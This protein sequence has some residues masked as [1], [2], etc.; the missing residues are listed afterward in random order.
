MQVTI[1]VCRITNRI[2]KS[3]FR[4]N[5][6][7]RKVCEIFKVSGRYTRMPLTSS[8]SPFCWHRTNIASC[9]NPFQAIV[10]D[11]FPQTKSIPM[12]SRG[13]KREYRTERSSLT[14]QFFKIGVL[15]HFAIFTGMHLCWSLF[16]I[17][18]PAFIFNFWNLACIRLFR[19]YS[20]TKWWWKKWYHRNNIPMVI[21][22]Q[23][24]KDKR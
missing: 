5:N 16:Q 2:T 19:G 9:Y 13:V 7:K 24:Y 17:K 10:Y 23:N 22:R 21:L 20:K 3:L 6:V 8:S 15:K 1:E 14:Q 18:L 11:N 12:F 4:F